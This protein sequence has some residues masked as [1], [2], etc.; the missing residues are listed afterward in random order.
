MTTLI[1]MISD[2]KLSH[3][4]RSLR[5]ETKASYEY[6]IKQLMDTKVNGIKFKKLDVNKLTGK[7]CKLAYDMW[8]ERGIHFANK[9]I[10]VARVVYNHGMH[11]EIARGNPFTS[12]RRRTPKKRTTL[13]DKDQIVQ[14]L[15]TAYSDFNT[16]NIGLIAQM[17]YEW[18]QRVGDMR[19]LKWSNLN[20]SQQ[21]AHILQSK[22]RAEVYLPI[23][24]ELAEM[25]TQQHEEFGFQDYVAPRPYLVGG[26][27][28]PYT[29]YKLSKHSRA[30]IRAAG[31]P[32]TLRLSDLRRTGTTEMVQAGVGIGQIMSVTGHANPQSVKP[33]IKN[34]YDAANFA[35]TQRQ[36]HGKST[37]DAEQKEDIYNV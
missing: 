23:S 19:L 10:A 4:Y 31:L 28:E 2:Y 36:K 13:W 16:R 25:L 3:E 26:V 33:Y 8:C 11:M 34:T 1:E 12:V 7:M 35:L 5:E 29:M 30:L 32:D 21:R 37:L 24:D 17:A 14:L 15:D 27:Y 22:R 6:L 20:L 9:T 18:C